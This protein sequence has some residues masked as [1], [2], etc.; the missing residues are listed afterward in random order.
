MEGVR[1]VFGLCLSTLH[2]S[3]LPKKADQTLPVVLSPTDLVTKTYLNAIQAV[4]NRI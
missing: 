4:A 3:T 1:S 2:V